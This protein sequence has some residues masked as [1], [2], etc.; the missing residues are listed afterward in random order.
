MSRIFRRVQVAGLALVG[1]ASVLGL[2]LTGCF[3]SSSSTN[4]GHDAG[5]GG[6]EGGTLDGG[7]GDSAPADASPGDASDGGMGASEGGGG[8]AAPA[9]GTCVPTGSMSTGRTF[10]LY[11]SLP[12]GKVLVAGGDTA[13]ASTTAEVYDPTTGTFAPT[14][15]LSTGRWGY[16]N[17]LVALPNGHLL[18]A[19]GTDLSCSTPV[20]SAETF[21]PTTGTWATTGALGVA[22]FNPVTVALGD[23][24]VLVRGGYGTLSGTC[25]TVTSNALTS[26]ELYDPAA[27]TFAPAG[28]A[29][30]PR[31]AAAAALLP[32]G[33]ALIVAGEQY[34]NSPFNA[35]AE[36]FG[37]GADGGTGFVWS[38]ALPGTAGYGYAFVLPDGKALVNSAYAGGTTSYFDPS[39]DTF[40]TAPADPISGGGGCGIQL[41]S[42]DVF[43]ATGWSAGQPTALTEVFQATSATWVA[44]GSLSTARSVC[45]IAELPDGNVLVAGGYDTTGKPLATAEVCNPQPSTTP[46]G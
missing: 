14:G 26:A 30:T 6:F 17:P 5:S 11:A 33:D 10:S 46:G 37:T 4:G 25:G 9:P 15:S 36:V 21:D 8:P 31:A 18:V 42:G 12:G 16:P 39:T 22:R 1:A 35:T 7:A 19:G 44:T 2:G 45:S 3:G 29:A 41:K 32:G 34:G 28:D 20:S 43:L 40:S 27:G 38:G 23:G 24:R 13:A